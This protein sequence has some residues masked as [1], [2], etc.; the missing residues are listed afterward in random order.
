MKR[1]PI[2]IKNKKDEYIVYE[3]W[4]N[5]LIEDD[6][7]FYCTLEYISEKNMSLKQ[8]DFGP[9]FTF[10][11]LIKFLNSFCSNF[12]TKDSSF[13]H[14]VSNVFFKRKKKNHQQTAKYILENTFIHQRE[15]SQNI[16]DETHNFELD[17]D[18][19]DKDIQTP[20]KSILDNDRFLIC[21]YVFSEVLQLNLGKKTNFE[22]KKQLDEFIKKQKHIK[23]AE[24]RENIFMKIYGLIYVVILNANFY[25]EKQ[26][27]DF[28]LNTITFNNIDT[29]QELNALLNSIVSDMFEKDNK[30]YL[31]MLDYFGFSNRSHITFNS[32]KL[33]KC[34]L[35]YPKKYNDFMQKL[36][37]SLP[38]NIYYMEK[39]KKLIL[40]GDSNDELNNFI[41][42]R[43]YSI[44]LE[45]DKISLSFKTSLLFY[46]HIHY[47]DPLYMQMRSSPIITDKLSFM[48][49]N[50][51]NML[52]KFF[53]QMIKY[54]DYMVPLINKYDGIF[55]YE[56]VYLDKPLNRPRFDNSFFKISLFRKFRSSLYTYDK[57]KNDPKL[58]PPNLYF[59]KGAGF[60]PFQ[61]LYEYFQK[62]PEKT[63]HP[64]QYCSIQIAIWT[65]YL[66]F[67]SFVTYKTRQ[68]DYLDS[69]LQ[70]VVDKFIF[71]P[72]EKHL[73]LF[74]TEQTIQID[75]HLYLLMGYWIR[76]DLSVVP[77]LDKVLEN[78]WYK[79]C[80]M[81]KQ[82]ETKMYDNIADRKFL[83]YGITS[84]KELVDR[85]D[86]QVVS[87]LQ[88][89]GNEKAIDDIH[90]N[91]NWFE[92]KDNDKI[93]I[94]QE[95]MI[96]T[97]ALYV[98]NFQHV[99]LKAYRDIDFV[100]YVTNEQGVRY[101]EEG[102]GKGVNQS[103]ISK[104][105]EAVNKSIYFQQK[106]TEDDWFTLGYIMKF[107]LI[108][109]YQFWM[110]KPNYFYKFLLQDARNIQPTLFD[111][112]EYDPEAGKHF[113]TMLMK[114]NLDQEFANV[115][116]D[117]EDLD[118]PIF[119]QSQPVT[120]QNIH[121]YINELLKKK[122][123][124]DKYNLSH[125]TSLYNGFNLTFLDYVPSC[126][127][128]KEKYAKPRTVT[129]EMFLKCCYTD[130]TFSNT[131]FSQ[132]KTKCLSTLHKGK[133]CCAINT[134]KKCPLSRFANFVVS[135]PTALLEQ[136]LF[137]IT[138]INYIPHLQLDD[139]YILI[140]IQKASEHFLP[141]GRTCNREL[142]I[143]SNN[144]PITQTQ[145]DKNI[146]Y[147]LENCTHFGY[148]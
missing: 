86:N 132:H 45:F 12:L 68:F 20:N 32:T 26:T 147:A 128:L 91:Q 66:F 113:V 85:A 116:L 110:D 141:E 34:N 138:G 30:T 17:L 13:D 144:Q 101:L 76:K 89:F 97:F 27:I 46:D 28:K 95:Q 59:F 87:I 48:N 77:T 84:M 127:V 18:I 98:K 52:D 11:K 75:Q 71:H 58:K 129:A 3:E 31:P 133:Y 47:Q 94:N 120:T 82:Y 79:S 37:F 38:N 60:K 137:Y 21:V 53:H 88:L 22:K 140:T 105:C 40:I 55:L 35:L 16:F 69:A 96:K 114:D 67:N 81:Y 135:A 41:G 43:P 57:F 122:L 6:S 148:A 19:Q 9:C 83:H 2:F 8:K 108:H 29:V 146:T 39:K 121:F 25:K 33:L 70:K 92:T 61:D 126:F 4:M 63:K 102:E 5:G 54:K 139:D 124:Y 131:I 78:I 14:F 10:L 72:E 123:I 23:I 90:V 145:F 103:A 56:N 115:M 112:Y 143:F 106:S 93:N 136:L 111:Y 104:Y 130:N 24:K 1:N 64:Q 51:I 125:L 117:F 119:N 62:L 7:R 142:R 50:I 107:C 73:N 74:S 109:T 49:N 99:T 36:K 118:I 80:L 15:F 44:M 134:K 42:F 100:F 65:L